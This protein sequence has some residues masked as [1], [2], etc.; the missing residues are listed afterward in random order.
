MLWGPVL[1]IDDEEDIRFVLKRFLRRHKIA[2]LT[3]GGAQE[4]LHVLKGVS[5]KVVVCDHRLE[6]TSGTTLLDAIG[7]WYPEKKRILITGNLSP[8]IERFAEDRGIDAIEKASNDSLSR[9]LSA[10]RKELG[11]GA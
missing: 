3:A 11:C 8:E 10:V 4:A 1:I 5:V 7:K 6:D 2:A 9:L